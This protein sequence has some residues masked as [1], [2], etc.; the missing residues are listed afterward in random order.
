MPLGDLPVWVGYDP[1]GDGEDAAAIVVL[2]RPLPLVGNTA[3]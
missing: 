2:R 1:S 3:W